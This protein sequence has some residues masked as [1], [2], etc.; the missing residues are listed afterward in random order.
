MKR[1]LAFLLVSGFAAGAAAQL[2]TIP[3]DAKP[4]RMSHVQD[5]V[6]ELDGRQQQL[7]RG[8]QIRDASNRIIMP[9]AL[10][11]GTPVKYVLDA[12]GRIRQVW[13]LTPEEG[14]KP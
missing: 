12:E 5:M 1:L 10:P 6:V 9:T 4:G 14:A 8:A 3:A 11:G 7:A 13:V 2:R